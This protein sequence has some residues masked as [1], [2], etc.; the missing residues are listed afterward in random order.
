MAATAKKLYTS[1]IGD[2]GPRTGTARFS[3]R[4]LIGDISDCLGRRTTLSPGPGSKGFCN[5]KVRMLFG[6]RVDEQIPGSQR[7][8]DRVSITN[9]PDCSSVE[10]TTCS[11]LVG[12]LTRRFG[13]ACRKK[14]SPVSLNGAVSVRSGQSLFSEANGYTRPAL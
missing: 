14:I 10:D 2:V 9:F 12:L 13:Q 5:L 4:V 11:G 1:I 8:V 6:L 3:T 7:G